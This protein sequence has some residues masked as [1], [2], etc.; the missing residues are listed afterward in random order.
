MAPSERAVSDPLYRQKVLRL[1]ADAHGAGRLARPDRTG[2]AFNPAC[3]DR[4][5]VDLSLANGVI[6][7]FAHETRACVLAQASASILGRALEGRTHD[8]IER[9][10]EGVGAMLQG[11][12]SAP[13]APFED[14]AA[15][16]GAGT[17]PA[18]HRCVLL[19]IE[20]VLEALKTGEAG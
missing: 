2:T 19:P 3:G 12:G 1:A 14:Y 16:D 6:T 5:T 15:L 20:A 4:V 7:Q 18:R 11:R 9:L 8:D 17:V 10:H 13:P